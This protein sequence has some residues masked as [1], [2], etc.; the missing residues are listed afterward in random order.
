MQLGIDNQD[1][2]RNDY[3]KYK[4]TIV[5]NV[6]FKVLKTGFWVNKYWSELGFSPDGL[7]FDPSELNK[8]GLVEI[9]C[10]KLFRTISPS[11]LFKKFTEKEV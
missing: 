1:Q 2:A 3:M 10:L 11:D 7:V 8:Y 9:K 6:G 4:L 5:S